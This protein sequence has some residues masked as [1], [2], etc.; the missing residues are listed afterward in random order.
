MWTFVGIA[1]IVPILWLWES[2]T[3]PPEHVVYYAI[4]VALLWAA[5]LLIMSPM[6]KMRERKVESSAPTT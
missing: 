6:T 3:N 2:T 4:E 5:L 1:L